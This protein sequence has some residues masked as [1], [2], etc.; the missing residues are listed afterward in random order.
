LILVSGEFVEEPVVSKNGHVYERS[1]IEKH[2]NEYHSDPLTHQPLEISDLI[3]LK[4]IDGNY[5]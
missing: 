4:G 3:P 5:V 2:V 1:V